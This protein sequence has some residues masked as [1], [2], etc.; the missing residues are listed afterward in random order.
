MGRREG[1]AGRSERQAA[2]GRVDAPTG[3]GGVL[4]RVKRWSDRGLQL[5]GGKMCDRGRGLP[6]SR[7]CLGPYLVERRLSRDSAWIRVQT[8]A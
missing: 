1:E 3:K 4:E 6:A 7:N 8:V 5:E 2:V